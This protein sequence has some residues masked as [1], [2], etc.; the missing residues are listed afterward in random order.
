MKKNLPA[1]A[2]DTI[3]YLRFVLIIMVVYSHSM[4]NADS[5]FK[6]FYMVHDIVVV[7][8]FSVAVPLFFFFSGYL[9]FLG[10]ERFG[11]G[12]YKSKLKKR[13]KTLL[14]PYIIWSLAIIALLFVFQKLFPGLFSGTFQNISEFGIRDFWNALWVAPIEYQ[15]W[16]LRDLFIAILLTPIIWLLIK[17][18]HILPILALCALYLLRI[19]IPISGFGVVCLFFFSLGAFFSIHKIDFFGFCDRCFY[20]LMAL[21]I[22][23]FAASVVIKEGNPYDVFIHRMSV[24]AGVFFMISAGLRLRRLLSRLPEVFYDS[25]FFI[26]AFHAIPIVLFMRILEKAGF[27]SCERNTIIAFFVVP[28]VII[29]ISILLYHI[30]RKIFPRFTSLITG[31]R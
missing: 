12:V 21:S 26:Y 8:L 5:S 23:L 28:V 25:T 18:L 16:F 10:V 22:V 24:I 11:F 4:P 2:S 15:F 17:Y 6:A 13:A 20:V 29:A 1:Y 30:L 27:L 3:K 7:N 19:I 31:G 14:L 9:F